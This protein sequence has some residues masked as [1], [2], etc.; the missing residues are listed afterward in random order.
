MAQRNPLEENWERDEEAME[1]KEGSGNKSPWTL[2]LLN[3]KL[4]T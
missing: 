3:M 2:N 4:I 1:N